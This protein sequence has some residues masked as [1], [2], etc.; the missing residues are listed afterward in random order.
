VSSFSSFNGTG[1]VYV[2]VRKSIVKIRKTHQKVSADMRIF[3]QCM[4]V[5][6]RLFNVMDGLKQSC[7][8]LPNISHEIYH[9]LGQPSGDYLSSSPVGRIT[10]SHHFVAVRASNVAQSITIISHST[11]AST[12]KSLAIINCYSSLRLSWLTSFTARHCASAVYAVVVCL[13]HA[14]IVSKRLNP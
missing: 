1:S 5:D 7:R 4:R 14:G 11:T 12:Y 10:D 9:Y 13:S 2:C 3:L 8:Y 6:Q